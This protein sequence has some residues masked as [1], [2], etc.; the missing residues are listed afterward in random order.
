MKSHMPIMNG[1]IVLLGAAGTDQFKLL[2]HFGHLSQQVACLP[3]LIVASMKKQY[4]MSRW[5]V[6]TIA[7]SYSYVATRRKCNV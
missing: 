6:E 4:E 2:S 1:F 7:R 3:A 5:L